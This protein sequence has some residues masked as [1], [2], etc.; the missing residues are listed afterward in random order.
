MTRFLVPVALLVAAIIHL[1]PVIGV[2]GVA[3]LQSL[4]GIDAIAPDLA[5]LMR[6]RAVL[7]GLLGAFLVYAAFRPSLQWLAM[8]AGMVSATSFL[9]IAW[10][11]GEYN[12]ALAN[13]VLADIVVV[14]A[15]VVAA[16]LRL[17]KP[18]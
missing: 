4:Y 15:L 7:F 11:V 18:Q 13:V 2:L 5:I 9:V 8:G 3:Q 14:L 6:H 1:V 17:T 12:T 10:W 16:A